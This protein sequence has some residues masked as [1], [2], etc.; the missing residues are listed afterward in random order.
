MPFLPRF[1]IR[2]FMP[3]AFDDVNYFGYGEYESYV[4]KRRASYRGLFNNKVADMHEDYIMPQENGSH[5]GCDFVSVSSK[6]LTLKAVSSDKFSFNASP[7]TQ[8]EL[9]TKQH[10]FELNECGDTVLCLDYKQSGI[11]SNSCGPELLEEYRFNEEYFT[12]EL[13]LIMN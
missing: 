11:G 6:G 5:Y 10:N 13:A 3:R 7:Y 9:T 2:L 8:E 12:F 4:D 1:G